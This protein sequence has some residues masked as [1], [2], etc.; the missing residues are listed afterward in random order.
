MCNP[1]ERDLWHKPAIEIG[2]IC[3]LSKL[4]SN[5]NLASLAPDKRPKSRG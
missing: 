3:Q 1:F 2:S 4:S 5:N